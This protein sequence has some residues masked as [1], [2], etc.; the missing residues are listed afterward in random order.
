MKK[1]PTGI[2][3]IAPGTPAEV[4]DFAARQMLRPAERLCPVPAGAPRLSLQR[5]LCDLLESEVSA[6][7]Q[8]F[9]FDSF[10]I[11]IGD[12]LNGIR[13]EG[14]LDDSDAAWEDDSAIAHWLHETAIRLYPDSDYARRRR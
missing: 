1:R 8:T 3:R 7:L 6:G 10:R 13:A 12:E 4:V 2:D 14:A 5:V 9:P 11:W